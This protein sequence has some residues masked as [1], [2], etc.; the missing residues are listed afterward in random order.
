MPE[1][2]EKLWFWWVLLVAKWPLQVGAGW[3]GRGVCGSPKPSVLGNNIVLSPPWVLGNNY[4]PNYL[5]FQPF[6]EFWF[7]GTLYKS[8]AGWPLPKWRLKVRGSLL[9][10]RD[11]THWG[12]G[13]VTRAPDKR[14]LRPWRVAFG[15][16]QSS[17][18][19]V[20]NQRNVSRL[21]NVIFASYKHRRL[22]VSALSKMRNGR[23]VTPTLWEQ[24]VVEQTATG[25]IPFC[26]RC[27]PLWSSLL[28]STKLRWQKIYRKPIR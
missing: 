15:P 5:W 8:S 26:R 19:L 20:K 12:E 25:P 7:G 16:S 4:S 1:G 6:R 11:H 17:I 2:V 18:F 14:A 9:L 24:T 10:S 27:L 21:C 22:I 28:V 3:S 13:R 23:A